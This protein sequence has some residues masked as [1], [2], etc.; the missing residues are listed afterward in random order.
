MREAD[1][2]A[3]A[4]DRLVRAA[5]ADLPDDIA[6]EATANGLR[7]TGPRLVAR[8]AADVRL[9]GLKAMAARGRG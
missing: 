6:A 4:V 2:I 3:R 9:W 1:V 7:L 8:W 5:A